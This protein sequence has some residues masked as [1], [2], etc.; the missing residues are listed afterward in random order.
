MT[1]LYVVLK[2]EW[3]YDDSYYS[4]DTKG[5]I[6]YKAYADKAKALAETDRLNIE[7]VKKSEAT[8]YLGEEGFWDLKDQELRARLDIPDED[9][10]GEWHD[11]KLPASATDED[12]LAF[13]KALRVNFF[14][15]KEVRVES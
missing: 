6:P 14:V 2:T 12:V 8:E 9:G 15:M 3:Q 1:T 4:C 7:T 13:L 10:D 11:W 5:G